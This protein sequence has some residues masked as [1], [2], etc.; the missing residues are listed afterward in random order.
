MNFYFR[1]F[2]ISR[3]KHTTRMGERK[4]IFS[5]VSLVTVQK[6]EIAAIVD[7]LVIE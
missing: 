6:L 5:R 4:F 2:L 1:V 3:E 7:I